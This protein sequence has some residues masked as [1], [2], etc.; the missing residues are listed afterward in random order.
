MKNI[1]RVFSSQSSTISEQSAV[2]LNEQDLELVNG[3]CGD[4]YCYEGDDDC[5]RDYDDCEEEYEHRH[6]R[7][8]RY[9]C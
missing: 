1:F 8:H 7:H 2:D 4:H 6:R 9:H 5:Y 3:A